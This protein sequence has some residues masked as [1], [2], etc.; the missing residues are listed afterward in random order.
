MADPNDVGKGFK[1]LQIFWPIVFA[2]LS[3]GAVGVR[4][5][6]KIE[7]V[8]Q[9]VDYLYTNGPPSQAARLARIEERQLVLIESVGRMNDKLDA[10][11]TRG[12]DYGR[13]HYR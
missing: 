3:I 8:G 5:N 9:K 13:K 11:D 7:E 2:L 12:T 6:A 4:A 10:M 1:L